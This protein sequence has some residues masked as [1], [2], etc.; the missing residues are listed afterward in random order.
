MTSTPS[1]NQRSD[2]FVILLVSCSMLMYEILLTRIS[3]L[4]LLF[5]YSFVVVGNCLLGLGASGTLIMLNRERWKR[6]AGERIFRFCGLYLAALIAV[7]PFILGFTIW[8]DQASGPPGP[9]RFALFNLVVAV[10]FFFAGLVIG[11]LLTFN[12]A[13]VNLVYGLDLV[14]AALGCALLPWL[15][16]QVGAGG[17]FVM[18]VLLAAG[19]WMA[20]AQ[21]ESRAPALAGGVALAAAG[22]WL[23][24]T[25]DRTFPVPGKGAL[26]ITREVTAKLGVRIEYSKWTAN[27]R[28][29][30]I[31]VPSHMGFIFTRGARAYE[32]PLPEEKLILQDGS[33]GTYLLDWPRHP[34][35][36]EVLKRSTYAAAL[37]LKHRPRVYVIGVGGGNDVW[38]AKAMGASQVRGIELNAPILE[39]HRSILPAWSKGLI[40]D[41]AIE[42][43][44]GEGRSALMREHRKYDLIQMSGIDTWTALASGAY[45]LAENYLYTTEAI[46]SLY[47]HLEDGGIL[48]IIRMSAEMET[49]RLLSNL[50]AFFERRGIAGFERSVVCLATPDGLAA[51]LVK[52]GTFTADELGKLADFC[53]DAGVT[54]VYLP[55]R[56]LGTRAEQF[57]LTEDKAAFIRDFPRN[58]TPTSD[59]RPYFFNYTKW[60]N[61]FAAAPYLSEPTMV[62]QGNPLFILGQLGLST[63]LSVGLI[64]LPLARSRRRAPHR[65]HVRPFLVYFASLGVGFIAIE[66]VMM[67]K[68]TLF[69]GHPL[70][71]VTVT[72]FSMLLFTGIGSLVSGRW[73]HAN[74]KLAW[75]VPAG[76]TA[77][78]G[79]FALVSPRFV[80][81]FIGLELPA[82]IALTVAILAPIGVLLGVPFA[83]GIRLLDRLN[84]TLIPWAWAVNGCCTVIG[85][86]LTV[87]LSMNFGFNFVLAAALLLYLA[88]FLAISSLAPVR[89]GDAHGVRADVGRSASPAA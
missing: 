79:A 17:S 29:D 14:G 89:P 64:V 32:L 6:G 15:L 67:Q 87:V 45:M 78:V 36:L 44:H 72:L 75:V 2:L 80:S 25:L 46:E 59:D 55:G 52:R 85:S 1:R 41:P 7:Y 56:T 48:Q 40:D 19:A 26:Q 77:T 30:M 65:G 31:P 9:A 20:A 34:E 63:I 62:S 35:M 51:V 73:F 16:P 53:R 47:D 61:P 70:Y 86:I 28:I 50:H 71:S 83:Y 12:S 22:L 23:L 5:H 4:R 37:R 88:A 38:A 11:M 8:P 27:S 3:A 84:P 58:L 33:A 13:R 60:R 74:P 81:T 39:I 10:P 68:L 69:L 43:L 82:R 76:L 66:I 18:V 57:V 24:P 54:P 21:V 49:L 42:L